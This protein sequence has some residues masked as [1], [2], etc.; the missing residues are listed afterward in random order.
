MKVSVVIPTH[1]RADS[2][3]N[4]INSVL[5]Q[6]YQNIEIIV[7]SD[8]RDYLTDKAVENF[9][10]SG[11]IK[12]LSY[13][14]SKGANYARNQGIKASSGEAVAFLDD[15]DEWNERKIEK[16]V[17]VFQNDK[18]IGLVYTGN[19]NIYNDLKIKYSYIPTKQGDLSSN[20]FE[21]NYIGS[22]SSVMVR[23]DLLIKVEGFDEKLPAIQDYDLWIRICQIAN[24][25]VV[26][27]PLLYYYNELNN[28]QISSNT[29][30]YK[31]AE[32]ILI[33]KY[34]YIF[35]STEE[36]KTSLKSHFYETIIIKCLRNGDKR[37]AYKETISY[38]K[39]SKKVSAF[40]YLL[41]I[42]VPYKYILKLRSMKN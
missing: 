41:M 17:N 30:K 2:I 23:K 40:K 31:L 37:L 39:F 7:V 18:S 36:L 26:S 35:T 5:N 21:K 1:K 6:T 38:F 8:G 11:Q 16:Q 29:E 20:I 24:V 22:T 28:N 25:G 15:D 12:Y 14:D 13:E 10:E 34:T 32:E 4:A 42:P 9:V 3:L 33:E 19:F 27:E